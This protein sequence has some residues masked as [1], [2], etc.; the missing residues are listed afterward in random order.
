VRGQGYATAVCSFVTSYILNQ[1]RRATC[2]T[3]RRRYA[4]V[5]V[6]RRVGYR[7]T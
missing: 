7:C 1:G 2:T 5:H 6:A 3:T 4:M